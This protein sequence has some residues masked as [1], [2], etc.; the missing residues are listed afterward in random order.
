MLSE[1]TEYDNLIGGCDF[2]ETDPS[3]FIIKLFNSDERTLELR[4][5]KIVNNE[6]TCDL[7]IVNPKEIELHSKM[8]SLITSLNNYLVLIDGKRVMFINENKVL[9]QTEVEWRINN[10]F[11][12]S[13]TNDI[14]IY[15]IENDHFY[16]RTRE[17]VQ[18][19]LLHFNKINNELKVKEL[20]FDGRI[21]DINDNVIMVEKLMIY[22]YKFDD[23]KINNKPNPKVINKKKLKENDYCISPNKKYLIFTTNEHELVVYKLDDEIKQ[24]ACL[25]L[26]EKMEYVV[27]SDQY[28]SMVN[29]AHENILTFEII[30]ETI[31]KCD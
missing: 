11:S 30:D 12:V 13:G 25:K 4:F 21:T 16:G 1:S 10:V 22:I 5:I 8:T 20:G 23:N 24:I 31:T 17:R 3:K 6:C 28:I 2:D 29:R 14:I 26:N 7:S 19:Q 15:S 27:S 18:V 9:N